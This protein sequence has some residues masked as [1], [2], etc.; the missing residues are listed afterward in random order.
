M[1]GLFDYTTGNTWYSRYP[2]ITSELGLDIKKL[3]TS[4]LDQLFDL[5]L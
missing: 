1:I 5:F 4:N 3:L 2:C